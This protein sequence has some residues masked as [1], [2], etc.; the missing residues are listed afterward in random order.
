[1]QEESFD[2]DNYGG[3]LDARGGAQ[4]SQESYDMAEPSYQT[5]PNPP[6]SYEQPYSGWSIWRASNDLQLPAMSEVPARQEFRNRSY[7]SQGL[8]QQPL[9]FDNEAD[10]ASTDSRRPYSR[11]DAGESRCSNDGFPT[12]LEALGDDIGRGFELGTSYAGQERRHAA[13]DPALNHTGMLINGDQ[14]RPENV[15][16]PLGERSTVV[17]GSHASLDVDAFNLLLPAPLD[18]HPG[19]FSPQAPWSP[20]NTHN[21][22]QQPLHHFSDAQS[23]IIPDEAGGQRTSV[24][25]TRAGSQM[26][27]SIASF[28]SR[29]TPSTSFERDGTDVHSMSEPLRPTEMGGGYG[30]VSNPEFVL[31]TPPIPTS[32]GVDTSRDMQ[33][34]GSPTINPPLNDQF[35]H[36]HP[37]V[38]DLEPSSPGSTTSSCT[39][40]SL[41]CIFEGCGSRFT[42]EYRK[43]NMARHIRLRHAAGGR[44][45][46]CAGCTKKFNR[47]D[48]RLKHY[49]RRHPHLAPGPAIP[50]GN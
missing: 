16:L 38:S 19:T 30:D 15:S 37:P 14:D 50:R 31:E 46:A 20:F 26:W 24:D 42:G 6:S 21:T 29:L 34:P 9:P 32:Y 8:D 18:P 1:M 7:D 45:Y 12:Q 49:R 35:L 17:H 13:E 25:P 4:T 33:S 48:A 27:S 28:P 22:L 36:I 39:T 23:A 47:Q 43:G 44:T 10:G 11:P 2:P 5:A 41:E 40:R 3:H